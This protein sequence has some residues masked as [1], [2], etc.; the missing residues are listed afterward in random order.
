VDRQHTGAG[1]WTWALRLLLALAALAAP[2]ITYKVIT[3]SDGADPIREQR[4]REANDAN[5]N[6]VPRSERTTNHPFRD[7][8][9]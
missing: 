5:R 4:L 9:P 8:N 6:P 2:I 1:L 7:D 3:E